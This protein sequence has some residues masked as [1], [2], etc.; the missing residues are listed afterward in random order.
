MSEDLEKRRETLRELRFNTPSKAHRKTAEVITQTAYQFVKKHGN[1]RCA[2]LT[3]TFP[4]PLKDR[5][6]AM[7][8]FN[9]LS[10]RVLKEHYG[11][12]L[13]VVERHRNGGIH[14]HII[15]ALNFDCRTGFDF[16]S[17][18]KAIRSWKAR[19]RWNQSG[20][21]NEAK[22]SRERAT[23]HDKLYIESA[24]PTLKAHWKMWRE[25]ASKYGFGRTELIPIRKV[26]DVDNPGKPVAWYLGKYVSKHISYRAPEDK[27]MRMFAVSKGSRVINSRFSWANEAAWL[28]RAKLAAV[29]RLMEIDDM[30]GWKELY[31]AK[32][33]YHASGTIQAHDLT[34]RKNGFTYPSG[35]HAVIDGHP[36]PK[37]DWQKPVTIR[38]KDWERIEAEAKENFRKL[39]DVLGYLKQLK[40][41][42]QEL[43]Q[44]KPETQRIQEAYEA[45]IKELDAIRWE[46]ERNAR[47]GRSNKQK[48]HEWLRI[49]GTWKELLVE[50]VEIKRVQVGVDE[51]GYPI[52][53]MA[54]IGGEIP[55]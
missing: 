53:G 4:R 8:R 42:G 15:V 32:W 7:R 29:S 14:F 19:Y 22:E 54:E 2:F 20:F 50:K 30:D 24:H 28:W 35:K 44:D 3:L 41:L 40:S 45:E 43:R 17:Y 37:E 26:G 1:E 46:M 16:E 51:W 23:K 13:R 6:E 52:Y 48:V 10:R 25:T 9:N 55:F 18:L 38:H 12:W 34:I 21:Y 36:I 47:V 5:K 33:A 11:E 27:G 31:G 49:F 39:R